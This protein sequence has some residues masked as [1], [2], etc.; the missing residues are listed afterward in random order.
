MVTY[1]FSDDVIM[2]TGGA[3][4]LGRNH[5]LAFA[6]AGANVI[7][8]DL[9]E[10]EDVVSEIESAGSRGCGISCDVSDEAQV[11]AAVETAIQRFGQIDVLVN[12]AGI[13]RTGRLTECDAET[14]RNVLEV[15][16]TGTW[17]CAKHVAAHMREGGMDR[18]RIVNT[19]SFFGHQPI[20][21]IGAYSASK[22]GVRSLTR[23]LALE[24]ADAGIRVNAVSPIGVRTEGVEEYDPDSEAILREGT[25][26]VGRYNLLEPGTRLEPDD[27]T[28]AVM[29]LSSPDA[30]CITGISLPIDAGAL[31]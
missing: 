5:A 13:A 4:G 17:L 8:L 6:E 21:G 12:N 9:R 28:N 25:D 27:V 18:G 19:S 31:A 15:N 26:W 20:P 10:T 29:W 1:D 2:I 24:L 22:F 16:L 3:R 23:T 30:R 11:Q 7:V 14:W